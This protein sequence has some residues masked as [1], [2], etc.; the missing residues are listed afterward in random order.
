ML[1]FVERLP[2]QRSTEYINE[3]DAGQ[4][5]VLFLLHGRAAEAKTIFAMEGMLDAR[6][7]IIALKAPF[8][9]KK[10]AF[11]WFEASEGGPKD[12]VS[13]ESN[14]KRSEDLLTEQIPAMLAERQLANNPLFLLGFSQGAAMSFVLGLRGRIRPQGVVAM[15]GFLPEPIKSWPELSTSADYLITHGTNDEVLGTEYSKSAQQFLISKGIGAEYYEYR[16]RHRMTL[17]CVEHVNS[18]LKDHL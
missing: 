10:G 11:E 14:F 18:W 15:S 13:D 7:H 3:P 2:R 8:P 16:G 9:S 1:E 6:F 4:T 5:P 17:Q 12:V